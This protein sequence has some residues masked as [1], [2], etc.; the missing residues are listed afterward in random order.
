MAA[1]ERRVAAQHHRSCCQ[2]RGRRFRHRRRPGAAHRDGLRT[3]ARVAHGHD[4]ASPVV[5]DR[6]EHR[7]RGGVN[8]RGS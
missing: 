5:G 7:G 3:G 4:G 8:Q 2:Q 6:G 1:S